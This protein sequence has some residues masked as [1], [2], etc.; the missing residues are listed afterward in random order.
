MDRRIERWG[1][2]RWVLPL[3][4]A[5][6]SLLGVQASAQSLTDALVKAY[7]SNPNLMAERARLRQSDEQVAQ[8]LSNWRPTVIVNADAGVQR[9]DRDIPPTVRGVQTLEPR[10]ADVRITQN[11]YRGGSTVAAVSR[12]KN[13]VQADRARL[14]GIE[15]TVMANTITAYMDVVRDQAVVELTR[16]NER[17]LQRQLEATRDRFRVGEVTRTDVAQAESRLQRATADRIQAEGNLV[18][19]RAN[20][21]SVVGD[22]PERLEAVE[23]STGLPRGEEEAIERARENNFA[24]IQARFLE[25]AAGDRVREI[26][27]EMLPQVSVDGVYDKSIEGSAE[28]SDVDT[29]ALTARV[30]MPLYQAGAVDARIREAKELRSQRRHELIQTTRL[31]TQ[32]ATQ[33]WQAYETA[34]ARTSAFTTQIAAAK[35]ALEGVEQ[36]ALVGSRTVLDVLDAEQE[37]LNAQ[38]ELVRAQRDA[39]VFSY[40]VKSAVGELT[41]EALRL[42]VD[43]YDYN[44]HYEDTRRRWFGIGIAE[45]PVLN[46]R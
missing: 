16:N 44:R 40:Q 35:I 6:A 9:A 7:Q 31:A 21:R 34:Q 12:T 1:R 33:T 17:V 24:V 28:N 26:L 36:E 32:N 22:Q 3:A 37:Y 13:Q 38:V 45:E 43:L 39:V 14:L 27:G 46:R 19:S 4:A 20:Y 10:G 2:L 30:R 11:I 8:A 5:G 41:A 25:V 15:Q 29:L 23:P 42:P 18:A